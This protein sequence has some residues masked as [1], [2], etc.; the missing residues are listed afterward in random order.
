MFAVCVD[1]VLVIVIVYDILLIEPSIY[2][3]QD[4][5]LKHEK[6]LS[7]LDKG[8]NYLLYPVVCR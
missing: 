3:L 5:L 8:I 1:Q 2:A 6:E 7:S 4:L